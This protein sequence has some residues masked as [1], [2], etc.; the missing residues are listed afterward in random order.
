M[1]DDRRKRGGLARNRIDLHNEQELRF[2]IEELQIDEAAL[3]EIVAK[4]G[5][6]ADTVRRHIEQLRS[7]QARRPAR[8]ARPPSR[9]QN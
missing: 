6:R 7:P 1:Q 4:V 8:A 2:W 5:T 3:R 9:R